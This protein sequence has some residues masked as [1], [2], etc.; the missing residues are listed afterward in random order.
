M[1]TWDFVFNS[2]GMFNRLYNPFRQD[3]ADPF[4]SYIFDEDGDVKEYEFDK[5]LYKWIE[6]NKA[7][8]DSDAVKLYYAEVFSG[9]TKGNY[10]TVYMWR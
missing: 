4:H 3:D 7:P 1:K 6:D 2:S 10:S 8:W 5:G 9:N